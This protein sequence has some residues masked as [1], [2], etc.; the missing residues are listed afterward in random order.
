MNQTTPP[1]T[2]DLVTELRLHLG[3]HKTATTHLQDSIAAVMAHVADQGVN[4]VPRDVFRW[5]VAWR[6]LKNRPDAQTLSDI[7]LVPT[8]DPVR[9]ELLAHVTV[10]G[11][12]AVSEENLLGS[13]RTITKNQLY[14][15]PKGLKLLTRLWPDKPLRLFLCIRSLDDFLPSAYCQV[16]K[17]NPLA[18]EDLEAARQRFLL[19]PKP[20]FCLVKRIR[21][22]APHAS[23]EVW[24]YDEYRQHWLEMHRS[25]LGL[26]GIQI[27]GVVDPVSTRRLSQAMVAKAEQL[28]ANLKGDQR[29]KA[30][31]QIV[32]QHAEQNPDAPPFQPFSARDAAFFRDQFQRDLNAIEGHFPGVLHSFRGR[33]GSPGKQLRAQQHRGKS[34]CQRNPEKHRLAMLVRAW[35]TKRGN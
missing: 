30:V 3:A 31:F 11:P 15:N 28:P 23:L 20:W 26:P 7:H 35:W 34:G 14:P 24:N 9:Q 19:Q 8:F 22:I 18:R 2:P 27:A 6:K 33:S 10:Q 32:R 29:R 17:V 5:G 12:L 16:I 4:Y 1:D 21:A 13:L 25:F